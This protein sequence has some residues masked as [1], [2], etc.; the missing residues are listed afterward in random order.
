MF[1]FQPMD[2]QSNPNENNSYQPGCYSK[3]TEFVKTNSL[4]IG[5]VGV[6]IAILMV[7]LRHN[8]VV[9]S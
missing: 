5:G 3:T 7:C 4:I 1:I 9:F 6:A 2:C 8:L